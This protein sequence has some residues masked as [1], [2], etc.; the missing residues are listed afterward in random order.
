VE[1]AKG[2]WLLF[3]EADSYHAPGLLCRAMAYTLSR[4]LAVLSLAPRHECRSFWEHVWQPLALQYLDFI[5]PMGGVHDPR[6]RIMWASGSFLLIARDAYA[7]AGGHTAV[8]SE[9]HAEC[10]VT[11]RVRALGYRVECVKAVDL[12]HVRMYQGLQELWE[13]WSQ[14]WYVLLDARPPLVLAHA[15]FLWAWTILPFAALLPALSF[16]LWGLDTIGGWWDIIFAVCT[17]LAVVTILQA[18]S[19]L[20]RLQR[21]N[22]VYAVTLPL[23]GL[24][25]GAAA[26]NALV[27]GSEKTGLKR[28][29]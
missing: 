28:F 2:E 3:T 21:Q 17:I 7:K 23:G 1:V 24:C 10:A 6:A 29:L 5:A 4:E 27:Q 15:L 8:A 20:R 25:L 18:H 19:V 12:L 11:R 22:H 26:I 16:G 9:I 13:G 14:R